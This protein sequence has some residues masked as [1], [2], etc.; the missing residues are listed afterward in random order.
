MDQSSKKQKFS[1]LMIDGLW[2]LKA[3]IT[4]QSQSSL[5]DVIKAA[6]QEK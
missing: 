6:A 2:S 1:S 3:K 5:F 4:K